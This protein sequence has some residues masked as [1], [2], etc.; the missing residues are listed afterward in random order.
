MKGIVDGLHADPEVEIDDKTAGRGD[1]AITMHPATSYE[2]FIEGI[3]PISDPDNENSTLFRYKPGVF[4]RLVKK[5]IQ[6]PNV[7]HV[8]L[9]DELNRCNVPMVLGDLLTTLERGKEPHNLS[10]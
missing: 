9:L 4:T 10:S 3:R 5:A 6:S 7:T 1:W 8:V 2:D